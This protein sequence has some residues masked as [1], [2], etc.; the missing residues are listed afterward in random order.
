MLRRP[1]YV[2]GMNLILIRILLGLGA[3]IVFGY[4]IYR[5]VKRWRGSDGPE[6]VHARR[7]FWALVGGGAIPLVLAAAFLVVG[8]FAAKQG[9][10]ANAILDSV[11]VY[12]SLLV[13]AS[14]T[15]SVV[16]HIEEDDPLSRYV[17]LSGKMGLVTTS[18]I[19][20][21]L[22]LTESG[23]DLNFW[24]GRFLVTL[25]LSAD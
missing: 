23:I 12:A 9:A 19:S 24:F 10:E 20:A 14:A 15:A 18:A 6:R 1:G 7:T 21:G 11:A 25:G 13:L 22:L 3:A 5:I 8:A 2:S 16:A 4:S 17:D